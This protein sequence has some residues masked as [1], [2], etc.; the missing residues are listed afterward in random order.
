M[1]HSYA[2]SYQP[3]ALLSRGSVPLVRMTVALSLPSLLRDVLAT[4]CAHGLEQ[5][6]QQGVVETLRFHKVADVL[7]VHEQLPSPL[8]LV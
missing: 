7:H 8:V 2:H 1:R 4:R 3:L 6:H 5:L